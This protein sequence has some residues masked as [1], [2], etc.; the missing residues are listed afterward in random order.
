MRNNSLLLLLLL[1]STQNLPLL[2][3]ISTR[4]QVHRTPFAGRNQ[5]LMLKQVFLS[6]SVINVKNQQIITKTCHKRGLPAFGCHLGVTLKRWLTPKSW[7]TPGENVIY[8]NLVLW[9]RPAYG[10]RSTR[11]LVKIHNT[12]LQILARYFTFIMSLSFFG[13]L[14]A[15]LQRTL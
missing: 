15:R 3:C 14:S 8:L 13:L 12:L 5:F 2:L 6:F 10:I 11:S 4:K 7:L 9:F 1:F